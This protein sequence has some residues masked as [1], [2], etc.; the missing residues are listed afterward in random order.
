M[1][2][3]D[4]TVNG[5]DFG[6]KVDTFFQYASHDKHMVSKSH[7]PSGFSMPLTLL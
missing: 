4:P 7:L 2:K 3:L 5:M 6:I 1:R